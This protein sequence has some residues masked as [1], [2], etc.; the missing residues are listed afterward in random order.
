MLAPCVTHLQSCTQA[1]EASSHWQ[2]IQRFREKLGSHMPTTADEAASFCSHGDEAASQAS[3]M[4]QLPRIGLASSFELRTALRQ[5]D[6]AEDDN[7]KGILSA[8]AN[9]TDVPTQMMGRLLRLLQEKENKWRTEL[10]RASVLEGE[11]AELRARLAA[12]E[13]TNSRLR[14][15]LHSGVAAFHRTLAQAKDKIQAKDAELSQVRAQSAQL[16]GSFLDA[17]EI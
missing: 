10:H 5:G 16:Q 7:S 1:R 17:I 14:S 12:S 2:Q 15:R 3:W 9:A 11:T 8:A 13:Q 6:I 4:S